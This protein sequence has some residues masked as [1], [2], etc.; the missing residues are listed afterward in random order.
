VTPGRL[1]TEFA[2]II[3]ECCGPYRR[4]TGEQDPITNEQWLALDLR[5]QSLRVLNM[6]KEASNGQ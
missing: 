2:L 4:D 1:I 6:T 5:W 3:E